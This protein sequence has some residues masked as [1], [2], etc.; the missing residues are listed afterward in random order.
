MSSM[1][2]KHRRKVV[3]QCAKDGIKPAKL[4]ADSASREI[5]AI[6]AATTEVMET[7]LQAIGVVIMHDWG[8]LTKKETRA[9]V[10]AK[11]LYERSIQAK[12]HAFNKDELSSCNDFSL[13]VMGVW[14]R[15]EKKHDGK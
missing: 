12:E 11:C 9:E 1:T 14:E 10:L 15:E 6:K 5:K 3:M 2:R 13:A 8:K 7:L 4:V